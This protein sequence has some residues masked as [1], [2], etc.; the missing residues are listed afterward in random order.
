MANIPTF[1]AAELPWLEAGYR[2][3]ARGGP[4]ALKVEVLARESGVSK[5]SFYHLFADLQFFEGRL[6]EL[7]LHK[8]EQ[9]RLEALQCR[10]IDPDL[11]ELLVRA[12]ID[13]LFDRQL[14]VNRQHNHY[15]R[16]FEEAN[17]G[18]LVAFSS[19]WAEALGLGKQPEAARLSLQLTVDNF[20]LTVTEENL[21]LDFL[22]QYWQQLKETIMR[23]RT[24]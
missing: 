6:L 2:I 12:K 15:R 8:S 19:V 5:S 10:S 24:P 20:Y 22:R 18:I 14:R 1:S 11:L 9:I 4:A 13:I 21:N 3:F 17:A 23:L 7:H 16:C